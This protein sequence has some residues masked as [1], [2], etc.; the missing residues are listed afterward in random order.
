MVPMEQSCVKCHDR[1]IG[2]DI[3]QMFCP[4]CSETLTP[5]QD[6]DYSWIE[7]RI[8]EV[9]AMPDNTLIDIYGTEKVARSAMKKA[10]SNEQKFGDLETEDRAKYLEWMRKNARKYKD[11]DAIDWIGAFY[12]WSEDG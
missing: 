7:R 11:G 6:I 9:N 12:D 1:F 5:M 2:S 3:C 8:M 10:L 4:S